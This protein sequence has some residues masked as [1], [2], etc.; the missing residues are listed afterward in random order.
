MIDCY[1]NRATDKIREELLI[2]Y[3]EE[4]DLVAVCIILCERISNLEA[5]IEEIK[6][7]WW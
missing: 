6:S 7:E 2:S 4:I 3:R 5:K 1:D